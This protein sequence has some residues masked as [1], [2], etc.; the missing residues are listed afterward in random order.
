M[1]RQLSVIAMKKTSAA[2]FLV[3]IAACGGPVAGDPTETTHQPLYGVGSTARAWG[4]TTGA[5]IPVCWMNPNDHMDLQIRVREILRETWESYANI[6]F[7]GPEPSLPFGGLW[8]P[9]S[10]TPGRNIG[11]AFSDDANFRGNTVGGGA[12]GALVTLI[13]DRAL[14]EN[15][16]RFRYEVIHEFGHALG[17]RH[18]MQRP[19]NWNGDTAYQCGG[20]GT[21]S[22]NYAVATGGLN[23][24][25]NYDVNSIMNYCNPAGFPQDLSLGD[26]HG[27][28]AVYGRRDVKG[29][30]Y[31]INSEK[32]LQWYRH[33]GRANG[34]FA[35][36]YGSGRVVGTGWDLKQVFSGSAS[37]GVLYGVNSDNQLL[38]Y[39]NAGR[40]DGS[41]RWEPGSGNVVGYGWDFKTLFSGGDGVIYGITPVV[42]ATL[43]TGIGP[44]YEGHPASGGELKW[45]R[46]NGRED[47]TFNWAS[48]SGNTVGTGWGAFAQVF[49][50]GNGVI[51]GI[52]AVVPA[53]L[54]TG[55]G[56][57]YEGHPASGGE[58]KWYRHNGREDGSFAWA[59]GSGSTVGTGWGAFTQVF[60]GGDGVIYAVAPNGDLKWYAH[61]G[62]TDGSFRWA[63][64]SGNVV[65][66][67][68][69]FPQ[70]LGDD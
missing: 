4:N 10:E 33:D 9:C 27:V 19:D 52:T 14:N 3:S 56:P 39:R 67:G 23:L 44:A 55:I 35:W 62:R 34:S 47:G 49:S 65:G 42:A 60:S 7:T 8:A 57:G 18:E 64:G 51:Y 41:F 15:Y 61:D 37:D 16:A 46:H 20:D 24:T 54:P 28:R 30:L 50:G 2:L 58:L 5:V 38:W 17:F 29:A 63:A 6:W 11:I 70:L 36:A 68:W 22:G 12:D 69:A 13:A 31:G 45:Y 48:G 26:I 32:Q 25:A 1:N 59:A 43:P 21:D 40:V 66:T 53:T